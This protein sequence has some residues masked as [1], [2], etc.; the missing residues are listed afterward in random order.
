MPSYSHTS[1]L[2]TENPFFL[3]PPSP[4]HTPF[5]SFCLFYHLLLHLPL[6]YRL[7]HMQTLQ[8]CSFSKGS[9]EESSR[10]SLNKSSNQQRFSLYLLCPGL[11]AVLFPF[12]SHKYFLQLFIFSYST[13]NF[14]SVY[15]VVVFLSLS[16]CMILL[17]T[18][19]LSL[20][21]SKISEKYYSLQISPFSAQP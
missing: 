17:L 12:C 18:L 10:E 20:H 1:P 7:S 15:F 5:L 14:Y 6:T 19:S 9:L 13:S 2:F 16:V 21:P 8:T 3:L 11:C 4:P